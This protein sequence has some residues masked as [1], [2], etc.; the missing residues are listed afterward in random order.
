M[1]LQQNGKLHFCLSSSQSTYWLGPNTSWHVKS[2]CINIYCR[3]N[4]NIESNKNIPSVTLKFSMHFVHPFM[5]DDAY[6]HISMPWQSSWHCSLN[7]EIQFKHLVHSCSWSPWAVW[8]HTRVSHCTALLLYILYIH[9]IEKAKSI[10]HYLKRQGLI[11]GITFGT[12]ATA[13]T[14]SFSVRA[15]LVSTECSL[16]WCIASRSH[17]PT[18]LSAISF[19][20]S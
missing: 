3:N 16:T 11:N 9:G 13:C 15:C 8:E 7:W 2:I 14:S 5:L 10:W 6:K 18:N 19:T 12:W 20:K 1:L 4:M 17:G